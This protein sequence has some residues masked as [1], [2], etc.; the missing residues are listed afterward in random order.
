M[1]NQHMPVEMARPTKQFDIRVFD[2]DTLRHEAAIESALSVLENFLADSAYSIDALI[3]DFLAIPGLT[4]F[5][6]SGAFCP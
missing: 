2:A 1:K 4:E 5:V 6:I 3:H